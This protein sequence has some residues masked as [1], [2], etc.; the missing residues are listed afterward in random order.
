MKKDEKAE[1]VFAYTFDCRDGYMILYALAAT[2][3]IPIERIRIDHW[4]DIHDGETSEVYSRVLFL[5]EYPAPHDFA[6]S[7]Y[8][9]DRGPWIIILKDGSTISGWKGPVVRVRTEPGR[10]TVME[11]L[12]LIKDRGH[13]LLRGTEDTVSKT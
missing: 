8:A 11:L 4:G 3:G 12:A 2:D 13:A 1:E 6:G 9:R 5:R 7:A 10:D